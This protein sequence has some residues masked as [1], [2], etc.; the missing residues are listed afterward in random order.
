[1]ALSQPLL[2]TPKMNVNSALFHNCQFITNKK[3]RISPSTIHFCNLFLIFQTAPGNA[4]LGINFRKGFRNIV[5]TR[6]G[7]SLVLRLG[8]T[9]TLGLLQ[10]HAKRP[11]RATLET[12]FLTPLRLERRVMLF[13]KVS[14]A[15]LH[16]SAKRKA[17]RVRAESAAGR[18]NAPSRRA[19][20]GAVL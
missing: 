7:S 5:S 10:N 2:P 14:Q 4:L 18:I 15:S 13:E 20:P 8:T 9:C 1:M 19:L 6:T 12:T 16:G 3:R 17:C 11:A